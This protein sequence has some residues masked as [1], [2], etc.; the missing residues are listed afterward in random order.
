MVNKNPYSYSIK[1]KSVN[2][3]ISPFL[4]G[5]YASG[6][7]IRQGQGFIG[8]SFPF[9]QGSFGIGA[10]FGGVNIPKYGIKDFN[11]NPMLGLRLNF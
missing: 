5:Q 9:R 11:I 2:P 3:Y 10:R 1:N 8:L 6:S 4:A 7:G